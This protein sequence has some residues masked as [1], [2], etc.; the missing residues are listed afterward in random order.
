MEDTSMKLK[1][2]CLV[3]MLLLAGCSRNASVSGT[4]TYKGKPVN[5]GAV[6]FAFEDGKTY[7]APIAAGNYSLMGLPA[8]LARIGVA[9][10]PHAIMGA[11]VKVVIKGGGPGSSDKIPD[12]YR[13]YSTSGLTYEVKPGSQEHHIEIPPR[14]AEG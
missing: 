1:L 6:T 7:T 9:D 12:H 8:G 11:K 4:V 5:A 14:K 2:A 13:D 10:G 3:G